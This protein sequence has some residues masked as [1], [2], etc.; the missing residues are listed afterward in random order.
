MERCSLTISLRL[1][2]IIEPRVPQ[3]SLVVEIH[4]L[5]ST[6]LLVEFH[7]MS[8]NIPETMSRVRIIRPHIALFVAKIF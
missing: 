6:F 2:F 5:L 3:R 8:R 4:S 7:S 1:L